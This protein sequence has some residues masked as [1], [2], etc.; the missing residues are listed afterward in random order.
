MIIRWGYKV[1][2]GV[3]RWQT[4]SDVGTAGEFREAWSLDT[5][6]RRHSD[7]VMGHDR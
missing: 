5:Q 2:G 7:Q 3:G 6:G 1:P 4:G